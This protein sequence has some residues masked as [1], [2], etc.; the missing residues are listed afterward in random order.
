VAE[1]DERPPIMLDVD[2]PL[3]PQGGDRLPDRAASC[4]IGVHQRSLGWEL[5]ASAELAGS[6]R[7]SKRTAVCW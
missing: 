5:R 4:S 3:G 6:D 2:E 1:P 7:Q